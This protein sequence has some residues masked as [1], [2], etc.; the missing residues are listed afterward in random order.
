M[1]CP[2]LSSSSFITTY[3]MVKALERDHEV[4]IL[5]PTFGKPLYIKD[6]SLR[7]VTIEPIVRHPMQAGYLSLLPKVK[8]YLKKHA[9]EY[10][11]V[12]AFKPV[13]HT[14]YAAAKAKEETRKPLVLSIDDYD[15]IASKNWMKRSLLSIAARSVKQA[16]AITV[17]SSQLQQVYGG[18]V[19]RQVACEPAFK[20]RQP[21]RKRIRKKYNI[22]DKIVIFHGGT[23][24]PH[25]GIDILIRAVQ[26]LK[27]R[28]H[29]VALLLAGEPIGPYR[30]LARDETIFCGMVPME[31]M[32]DYVAACDIYAIPTRDTP[33]ARA[34][35]PAKIFE[36]MMLGKAIVASSISDIPELLDHGNAGV[37][38][39]PDSVHDL[40]IKLEELI[41]DRDL[42]VAVGRN[43]KKRYDKNYSYDVIARQLKVVYKNF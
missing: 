3:P 23:F 18:T 15:Q 33:Y 22:E 36:P 34:E 9:N 31:E 2:L 13:F 19:I 8:A 10:D 7:I 20:R 39:R 32:P 5:G 21:E 38:S 37:L 24:Y 11:V 28:G 4:T 43:A 1:I 41:T 6:D 35:I 40:T 12:H 30:S 42:R 26:K 25:K 14:G 16:D 17:S 27:E 29:N